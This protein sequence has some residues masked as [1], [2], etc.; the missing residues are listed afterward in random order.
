MFVRRARVRERDAPD[1]AE[2]GRWPFTVPCVTELVEHGLTF[3]APVT[4][5]VGDNGSG[6]S[7]LVEAV[8]EAFGL[9]SYGG[10]L[11]AKRGHPE[12]STT[13]LGQRLSLE[14]TPAGSRMLGGPRSK[15]QGFFLR[16]ETAFRMT[17]RLGGVPGYW[18]PDT[19]SMSHGEGFLTVFHEMMASPGF[20]VMD[21]PEAALSFTSCLRLVALLHQLG[22]SGAQ[23]VCSTHSPILASTPGADIL[24][25]GE[26]GIDRVEWRELELVDHWRRYLDNP[27]T[28]LRH[29]LDT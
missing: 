22:E 24:E 27:D 14:T 1:R 4:F 18:E 17:E 13:E 16:A 29:L 3:R 20:Y 28:Y 7:T 9:D 25:V 12:P 5:L 2:R 15:K 21:E 8:A 26:Q 6:K 11:A 23:V 10:K 19:S